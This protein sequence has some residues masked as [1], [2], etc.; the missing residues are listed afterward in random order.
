MELASRQTGT[1]GLTHFS[2]RRSCGVRKARP[3]TKALEDLIWLWL[4]LLEWITPLFKLHEAHKAD[5]ALVA[6]RLWCQACL[7]MFTVK[8][9][10]G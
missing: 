7:F 6:L 9:P 1:D 5:M 4:L 2:V 3:S 10:A 8:Q